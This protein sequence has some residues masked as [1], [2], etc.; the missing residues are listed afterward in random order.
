MDGLVD[1]AVVEPPAPLLIALPVCNNLDFMTGPELSHVGNIAGP[2][3]GEFGNVVLD[4][5]LAVP[6]LCTRIKAYAEIAD[7]VHRL[8]V[9]DLRQGEVQ[10][11]R[12]AR[13][14][15]FDLREN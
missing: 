8:W 1:K 3:A 9:D 6:G 10:V 5:E 14:H 11:G 7:V 15:S 2:A 13:D 12:I 4:S